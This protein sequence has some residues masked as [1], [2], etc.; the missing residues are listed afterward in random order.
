MTKQKETFSSLMLSFQYHFDL[1]TVFEDF[2]TMSMCSLTPVLGKGVSYYEDLYMQTVAKYAKH[3]I[4]FNFPKMFACLVE[5]MTARVTSDTGNDVLGE[6]YEQHLYSKGKSQYFT[7][8][9]VCTFMAKATVDASPEKDTAKS[10]RILEP[11]C[12]S[13]RMLLAVMREIGPQHHYYAIDLDP[14]CCKMAAL[15]LFLNGMFHSEIMCGN[16]L[17]PEQFSISYKLSLFPPGIF[18]IEDKE[19]SPLYH[20]VKHYPKEPRE[21]KADEKV[22]S[23]LFSKENPQLRIF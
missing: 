17:V 9:P 4:R 1:R 13:G 21:C 19:L 7:P 23:D 18:R 14:V 11:A 15:N 8:W 3:N 12:G 2:L 5:E 16:A 6:F 22:D 20:M 10:L